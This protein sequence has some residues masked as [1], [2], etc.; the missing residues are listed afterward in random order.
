MARQ[1]NEKLVDNVPESCPFKNTCKAW[2]D[3]CTIRVG[4]SPPRKN[5]SDEPISTL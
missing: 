3:D 4:S 1:S 5:D 2:P